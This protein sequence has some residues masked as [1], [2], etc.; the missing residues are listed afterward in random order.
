MPFESQNVIEKTSVLVDGFD[1]WMMLS[2]PLSLRTI[3]KFSDVVVSPPPENAANPPGA[4]PAP[5]R[6]VVRMAF[7]V[8]VRV[9][10]GNAVDVPVSVVVALGVRVMVGVTDGVRFGTGVPVADAVDVAVSVAVSVADGV[11]LA[12]GDIASPGALGCAG[13]G[14]READGVEAT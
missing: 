12:V 1:T 13:V 11:E 5:V 6:G 14:V 9:W 4:G 8:E 7:G 2:F 3:G 10:L